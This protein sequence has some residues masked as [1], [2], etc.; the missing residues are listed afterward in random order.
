MKEIGLFYIYKSLGLSPYDNNGW[1]CQ[2]D[3]T[4]TFI[5][6]FSSKP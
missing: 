2:L 6:K 4:S 1:K 5:V 3:E